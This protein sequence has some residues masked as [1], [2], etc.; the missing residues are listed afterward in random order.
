M[1]HSI[2][3]S[4]VHWHADLLACIQSQHEGCITDLF[5][6]DAASLLR[7]SAQAAVL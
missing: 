3:V 7:S 6:P 5:V 1:Q 4:A 2:V